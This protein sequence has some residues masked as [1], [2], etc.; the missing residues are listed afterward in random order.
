[1]GHGSEASPPPDWPL[2]HRLPMIT[3]ATVESIVSDN[4]DAC[5]GHL[6]WPRSWVRQ[7]RRAQACRSPTRLPRC[8]GSADKALLTIIRGSP[9]RS[10]PYRQLRGPCPGNRSHA[11]L[12][13]PARARPRSAGP[14]RRA[15]RTGRALVRILTQ[16]RPAH[17]PGT[18]RWLAA[19]GLLNRQRVPGGQLLPGLLSA[20]RLVWLPRFLDVQRQWA[21]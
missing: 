4:I 15:R 8:G 9:R 13:R 18:A 17:W 2:A 10:D 16:S 11:P 6:R 5:Q 20:H 12:P 21:W 7:S 3:E 1:M 14:G 19:L